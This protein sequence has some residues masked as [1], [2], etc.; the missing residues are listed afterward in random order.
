[1]PIDF[2]ARPQ[3]VMPLARDKAGTER[4]EA[5]CFARG[6]P[7]NHVCCQSSLL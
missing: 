6:H 2:S 5:V 3:K 1:M 4:A 7:G